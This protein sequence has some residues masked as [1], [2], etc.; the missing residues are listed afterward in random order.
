MQAAVDGRGTMFRVRI[1]PFESVAEASAYR[2]R[3]EQTEHMNTIV[4]RRRDTE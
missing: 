4:I 3:F 1:G 2:A